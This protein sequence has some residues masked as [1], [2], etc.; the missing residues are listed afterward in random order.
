MKPVIS[1]LVKAFFAGC[2]ALAM[3]CAVCLVY[4]NP[5]IHLT[6]ETGATDYTWQPGQFAGFM[7]EGIAWNTADANGFFDPNGPDHGM[8]I[9]YMGS[10]HTEGLH[11]FS[12][13]NAPNL[14][15]SLSGMT[16]YN[17]GTSGHTLLHCVKNLEAALKVH[18]PT[19][20][21]IIE[22]SVEPV[23]SREITACLD[24]TMDSI[25]SY[26]SGLLYQLQ[27]IP[28]LKLF[29]S[30]LQYWSAT[31]AAPAAS[32]GEESREPLGY[33]RLA[34]Y[35]KDICDTYGVTPILM[36][37]PTMDLLPS[38]EAV[39]MPNPSVRELAQACADAG[40]T[41]V[42]MGEDFLELYRRD[43]AL[44]HGFSNT[45]VGVGHLNAQG[46]RVIAQRL[47]EIIQQ[48]DS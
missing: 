5:G 23:S 21:V 10:S 36:Y 16:V 38:G 27:K 9:L 25:P 26:N 8:E 35:V 18:G 46:C 34:A 41:F 33:D 22:T 15:E 1:W 24:G 39:V 12:E 13:Q 14:L 28:Y 42:D 31:A 47:L 11:V 6:N 29:R 17:I 4:Y 20:Y 19:R 2:L 7:T 45:A 43:H 44:P 30:Q 32:G 40:V 48:L 3:A 37:H